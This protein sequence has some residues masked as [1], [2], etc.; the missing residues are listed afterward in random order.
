MLI[1]KFEAICEDK[2]TVKNLELKLKTLLNLLKVLHEF[3]SQETLSV[4]ESFRQRNV[5]QLTHISL[6]KSSLLS[7]VKSSCLYVSWFR[8]LLFSD[9]PA[10]S[11]STEIDKKLDDDTYR[12][13]NIEKLLN[14]F[15][16]LMSSISF[17]DWIESGEVGSELV[18]RSCAEVI[19]WPTETPAPTTMQRLIAHFQ[20]LCCDALEVRHVAR[21]VTSKCFEQNILFF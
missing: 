11:T 13:N 15:K 5:K 20:A 3:T 9:F 19:Y 8:Q 6:Y 17:D 16:M 18:L 2:S 21:R 1:G 7:S 14:V 10:D 12:G 4:D